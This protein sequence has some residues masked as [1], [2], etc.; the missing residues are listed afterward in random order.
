MSNGEE[1][2]MHTETTPNEPLRSGRLF[3]AAIIAGKL[4][5]AHRTITRFM[6]E[7]WPARAAEI[8]DLLHKIAAEEKKSEMAV[9]VERAKQCSPMA[10]LQIL[11]AAYE[12]AAS[13]NGADEG[14][15]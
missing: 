1:P 6:G 9:A 3:D 14:R 11:A 12:L 4:A 8:K 7:K 2:T 10:G 15:R 5:D 13:P